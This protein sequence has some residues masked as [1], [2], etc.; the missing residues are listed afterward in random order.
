MGRLVQ[1]VVAHE[2]GHALGFPHNMKAS[3]GYPADSVRSASF[4]RRMGHS[5]SVMDYARFNYVAQP[6]DN[7]PVETLVPR[8]GPYD[9]FAVMWGHKPISNAK[10]PDD[11]LPTLDHWAREQDTK[12]WLRF[13]TQGA[14]NDPGDQAEAV[15]DADPVHSTMLALKNME[16]VMGY[17]LPAAEHP[18]RDYT[19][20]SEL[21][22]EAVT[23]WG[24]YMGHVAAVVGGAESQERFGTGPR[25]RPLTKERQRA[26]V[27]FLNS[28]AFR[29]PA[30]FT[31]PDLLRRIEAEGV[32]GRIRAAQSQ[33]LSSLLMESRL[34][35]LIEYET[36]AR[37]PGE[38][39]TM[40]DLLTDLRAGVWSELTTPA[41]R[42]DV[43]RRNLQ[44]AYLETV[45]YH[46]QSPFASSGP[47]TILFLEVANS[48]PPFTSDVRP[49]LRG[50][51]LE[52]QREI[53][54]A[55]GRAGDPITRLHLRD[56]DF[57]ITHILDPN[58]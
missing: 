27:Q 56:L 44:R 6:E 26:A 14:F 15:G 41:P 45:A 1:N 46:F 36:L 57:E 30:Y 28:N 2:V 24:R 10:T 21:Y 12:P 52:L 50:E 23:Q 42:I 49:I 40:A 53:R 22:G 29:A 43:Y 38:A 5:P 7:I 34:V 54:S 20:L 31:H 48:S 17:M 13:S 9:R 32:I 18:G 35:R 33:V 3:S 39:Y 47:I 11:E 16:R 4:V 55:V 25:F 19:L 8:V 51:L 58:K 37:R